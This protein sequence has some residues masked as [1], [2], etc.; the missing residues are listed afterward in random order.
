MEIHGGLQEVHGNS[1]RFLVVGH[2]LVGTYEC[3]SPKSSLG[4]IRG[5]AEIIWVAVGFS[6]FLVWRLAGRLP[7]NGW[8]LKQAPKVQCPFP[9]SAT[10]PRQP[11]EADWGTLGAFGPYEELFGRLGSPSLG[12]N[13]LYDLKAQHAARAAQE[14]LS[15]ALYPL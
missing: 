11:N 3:L 10:K 7:P 13:G 12:S 9:L 6:F 1:E 4:L 14:M 8:M 5:C 2:R 15:T